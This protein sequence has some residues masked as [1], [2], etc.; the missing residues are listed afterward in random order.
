MSFSLLFISFVPSAPHLVLFYLILVHCLASFLSFKEKRTERARIISCAHSILFVHRFHSSLFSNACTAKQTT[1]ERD[2]VAPQANTKN[3]FTS[4]NGKKLYSLP[5][6]S[7]VFGANFLF[8]VCWR[9]FVLP[10]VTFSYSSMLVLVDLFSLPY[11]TLF[12]DIFST[13]GPLHVVAVVRC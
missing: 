9:K 1:K 10:H 12:V 5:I 3:V 2:W 11:F 6:R 7:C 8:P 4:T 13:L